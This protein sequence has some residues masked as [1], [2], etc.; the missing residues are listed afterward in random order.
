MRTLR[1]AFVLFCGLAVTIASAGVATVNF[2][3]IDY[4]NKGPGPAGG[5]PGVWNTQPAGALILASDQPWPR[6]PWDP[7]PAQRRTEPGISM[8]LPDPDQDARGVYGIEA[9]AEYG[10]MIYRCNKADPGGC[11]GTDP[12][13]HR[14]VWPGACPARAIV[15]T[16]PGGIR[17]LGGVVGITHTLVN[18]Q[19]ILRIGIHGADGQPPGVTDAI[20]AYRQHYYDP[21]IPFVRCGSAGAPC[22]VQYP[23]F[24][25]KPP[26]SPVFPVGFV[27]TVHAATTAPS[28]NPVCGGMTEA[29]CQLSG[30][31]GSFSAQYLHHAEL[32]GPALDGSGC[33]AVRLATL[34]GGLM[35]PDI[36]N[37]TD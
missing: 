27:V 25:G 23:N 7:N 4:V 5:V 3:V 33:V 28:Q 34:A 26:K 18:G 29:Q 21:S 15:C 24:L 12:N 17:V 10:A 13:V 32:T 11:T 8:P 14:F 20:Q 1:I 9:L 22:D 31:P 35:V 16:V 6:S 37:C 2:F 19:Y 30:I 36:I